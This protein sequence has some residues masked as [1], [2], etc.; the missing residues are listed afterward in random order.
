ME[1]RLGVQ[2]TWSQKGAT[3]PSRSE[4]KVDV[5][6]YNKGAVTS[7]HVFALNWIIGM[8]NVKKKKKKCSSVGRVY[9]CYFVSLQ[10]IDVQ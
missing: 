4:K 5:W 10:S 9:I 6:T 2:R 7:A 3:R 1:A 8:P